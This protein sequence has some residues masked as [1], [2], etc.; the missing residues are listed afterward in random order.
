MNDNGRQA[1]GQG[2]KALTI[3]GDLA[4]APVVGAAARGDDRVHRHG[5]PEN[6]DCLETAGDVAARRRFRARGR[7]TDS[8]DAEAI[9]VEQRIPLAENEVPGGPH[10]LVTAGDVTARVRG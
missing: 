10:C 3:P 2:R 5:R 1:W 4:E 7:A 8:E 6:P 9:R